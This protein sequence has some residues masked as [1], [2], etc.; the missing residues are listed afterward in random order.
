MARTLIYGCYGYTGRLIVA[1]GKKRGLEMLL[2]GRNAAQVEQMAQEQ[3]LPFVAFDLGDRAAIDAAVQQVDVVL[4]CAGP[5]VHTA[6]PMAVACVRNGKHYLDIT[7]EIAVFEAVASLGDKAADAGVM[8][9]P[10][11]GFDVV[12]TDCVAARL[13][14][15]LP[16]ATDLEI[17]LKSQGGGIS[18]GT[19][20]TMLE[21]LGQGSIIRR[22]GK[23]LKAPLAGAPLTADFGDGP[24]QAA[25]IPWG[26]VSTAWYTTGIP[27]IT[28]GVVV[29]KRQLRLM[30]MSNLMGPLLRAGWVKRML[31]RR[32]DKRPAGPSDA[33]RERG[34]SMVWGRVLNDKGAQE[35]LCITTPEGYTLTALAAVHIAQRVGRGDFKKGFQTPAGCYGPQLLD[36][37]LA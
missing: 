12:P 19:A 37:I 11:V 24:E 9:M 26:D 35:T 15:A 1:E 16:D 3:E 14:A 17:V 29:P 8:L 7:G 2:A 22:G 25:S 28:T 5:F 36:E 27:N 32:I 34:K 30:R 33:R 4:H 18:H 6:P 21:S 13:K 20:T 23:L 10:G 31:Q